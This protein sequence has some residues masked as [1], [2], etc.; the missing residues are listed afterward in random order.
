MSVGLHVVI[1]VLQTGAS[2]IVFTVNA[3]TV[4]TVAVGI[5]VQTKSYCLRII[6]DYTPNFYQN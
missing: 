5:P 1:I 6:N 3:V 2:N 4:N